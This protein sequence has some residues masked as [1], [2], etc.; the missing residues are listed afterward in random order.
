MPHSPSPQTLQ[1]LLALC[2][3]GQFADAAREAERLVLD[4]PASF[5]VWSTLGAACT[6]SGRPDRAEHAFR[7]AIEI[8]PEHAG[9]HY[10]LGLVLH[11]S[12]RLREARVAYAK[13]LRRKPDHADACNNMGNVLAD[14][15][16]P[17]AA[18]AAYRQAL[19]YR[20]DYA[21]AYSNL[22]RALKDTGE[23]GAAIAAWE[24]ALELVPGHAA[25]RSQK[26]C[27]QWQI[28]DFSAYEEFLGIRD[29]LGIVGARVPPFSLLSA[30][31]NPAHQRLRSERWAQGIAGTLRRDRPPRPQRRPDRLR[32]GYFSADFHEHPT[33]R[34]I[35]GLLREHDRTRFDI[36]AYSY[37]SRKDGGLRKQLRRDVRDFHDVQHLTPGQIAD[38]ARSHRLDIAIDLNGY[39]RSARSEIFACRP[40]GIAISFLGFPGTMGADF[41]DYLV[42]D[43]IVIPDAERAH[44][45][46][47]VLYLPGT[48]Q[49]NDDGQAI[50]ETTDTR[51]DHGLPQNG[52][53]FCCFNNAYKIG[54]R[55]F[56]I[57]MRLLRQTQGSVLWLLRSNT[58]MEANLLREAAARG[59]DPARLVFADRRPHGEHLAR[60]RHA[61]LFL[62]TFH[63]NAHTTASD[64]LRAGLPVVT[65]AGRQFAARV[66]AS[67][68][69]A[70]GL[71]GL[72]AGSE[73]EYEGLI[74]DLATRPSRR[75]EVADRLSRG[76]P[77]RCAFETS[78]YAR[79]FE[80]ALDAAFDLHLRAEAP[81]DIRLRGLPGI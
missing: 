34:L 15:G 8:M 6:K 16:R 27:M 72:V 55:E 76:R 74:L 60:H 23:F 78:R 80:A 73:D 79:H 40:A 13:A 30:E 47:S 42:A 26:L 38:L 71:P 41:I 12:G 25:A 46:E 2:R 11:R 36:L 28:C 5:A 18:A 68:L 17:D 63:C 1:H 48:Y 37:G 58:Q 32:V 57:W 59:V 3:S 19:E 50:P 61:D 56:D 53:V 69:T 44:Y 64:A 10:N 54:P 65:M 52:F 43:P 62:D 14:L 31:D 39:T 22:G 45:R 9:V 35:S 81:R 33:L 70:A 66:A 77:S 21:D 51:V 49:P 4:F 67:L 20:P 75:G 7:R 24:R 29:T